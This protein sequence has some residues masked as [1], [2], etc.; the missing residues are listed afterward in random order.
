MILSLFPPPFPMIHCLF[1]LLFILF[2][3]CFLSF[4]YDSFS[5]SSPFHIHS[6][7]LSLLLF[8]SFYFHSYF[9]PDY[10]SF[11]FLFNALLLLLSLFSSD[12]FSPFPI[13]FSWSLPP[14]HPSFVSVSSFYFILR[15]LYFPLPLPFTSYFIFSSYLSISSFF[16]R[17]HSY[18]FI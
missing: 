11:F 1:P 14:P 16:S 15:S 9:K 2:F 8:F 18:L 13:I 6:L 17:F 12:T 4:S 7:S 3:R 5:L 10:F